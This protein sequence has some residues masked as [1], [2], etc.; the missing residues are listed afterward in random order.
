M[1][2][3]FWP[4]IIVLFG[5]FFFPSLSAAEQDPAR[6]MAEIVGKLKQNGSPSALIEY[7]DWNSAYR[8]LDDR[9]RVVLKVNSGKELRESYRRIFAQSYKRPR[10]NERAK[11]E[12]ARFKVGKTK[13]TVDRA[14]VELY[15]SL[16]GRVS[17]QY[18]EFLKRGGTWRLT[19]P[20]HFGSERFH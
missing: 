14:Y 18:V 8:R 9:K 10:S 20:A 13:M 11:L 15:T 12:R 19:R 7:V 17:R 6:L 3:V 2:R 5:F 1:K 4:F 16:D